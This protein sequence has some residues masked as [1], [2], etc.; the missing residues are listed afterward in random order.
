MSKKNRVSRTS[1]GPQSRLGALARWLARRS[2]LV[3]LLIAGL[4]ALVLTGSLG[5]FIYSYLFSL[6]PG[7][8]YIG[9]L[10][11][12]DLVTILLIVLFIFGL[13]FYWIGWRVLVGFDFG[14]TALEPGRPAAIWVLV[15]VAVFAVT[16]VVVIINTI[17]ALLPS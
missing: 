14:E 7:S 11:P 4:V 17:I 16:L 5:L 9:S 6:S 1:S 3:R 13:A 12:L 15:G 2:R 8:L 10:K